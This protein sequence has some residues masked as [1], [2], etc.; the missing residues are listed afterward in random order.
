MK[1]RW[2]FLFVG[3]FI[4]CVTSVNHFEKVLIGSWRI[5]NPSGQSF[6]RFKKNGDV[7]FYFDR[8]RFEKDSLVE[9]GGWQMEQPIA[10]TIKDTLKIKLT[11]QKGIHAL[12]F[13]IES[14]NRLKNIGHKT[15]VFYSRME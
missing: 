6:V 8:Y 13:V 2:L 11:T 12:N 10:K 7:F 1:N 14:Q 5:E 15:N 9:K 4:C 3:L